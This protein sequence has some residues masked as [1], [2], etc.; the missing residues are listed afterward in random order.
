M[1]ARKTDTNLQAITDGNVQYKST[2][3]DQ[4]QTESVMYGITFTVQTQ[5]VTLTRSYI[6]TFTS[7]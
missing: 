5:E 1:D 7:I 6:A 2:L 3:K 4:G